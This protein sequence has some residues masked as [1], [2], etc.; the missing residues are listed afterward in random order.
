MRL[1]S[2]ILATLALTL[3]LSACGRSDA[4]EGDPAGIYEVD[5][6]RDLVLEDGTELYVEIASPADPLVNAAV[7]SLEDGCTFDEL[8]DALAPA[9]DLKIEHFADVAMH[10]KVDD[11]LR[12][13]LWQ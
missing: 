4:L 7:M 3:S 13:V 5:G 1:R 10:V 8:I 11:D 6:A 2:T 12:A 9:G